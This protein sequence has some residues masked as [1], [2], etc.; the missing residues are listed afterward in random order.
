MWNAVDTIRDAAK[1]IETISDGYA[2]DDQNFDDG[3][4]HKE[5]V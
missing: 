5:V 3:R 2:E 4:H 1:A